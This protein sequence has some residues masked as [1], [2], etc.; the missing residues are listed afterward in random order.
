[1]SPYACPVF[2]LSSLWTALEDNKFIFGI[3]M[4]VV[5][6]VMLFYGI[7]MTH[8][9]IFLTAYFLT[10][11]VLASIFTAFLTPDSSRVAIYFSLLFIIFLSTLSA[12]G[13]SKLVNVSIFFIGAC[14]YIC[15]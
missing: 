14:S 5:G 3:V 11:A 15:I 9:M 13:L 7:L 12:Y 6:F 10:F 4:F 2:E 1:M 8:L